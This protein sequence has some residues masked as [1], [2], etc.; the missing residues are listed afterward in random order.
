[1]DRSKEKY[2]QQLEMSRAWKQKNPKR[3]AE[4]AVAYR[5][6]NRE[7][8]Q[9]QN[10]LNYA[11]KKGLISRQPCE[12]CGTSERVHAHHDDYSKP[13]DVKWLCYLCHKK[14]HPVDDADKEIKFSG[15]KHASM[16]GESNPNASMTNEQAEQVRAMLSI[17]IS[18]ERIAK[19]MGVSQ[20]TI[21]KIK[22]RKSYDI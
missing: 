3:H 16:P 21:S 10:R 12:M 6:R 20:V 5:A 8:T 18:Q 11:V 13:L 22:R 14:T 17:G 15:A 9:A 7:K 2:E 1:M 4:L 19:A